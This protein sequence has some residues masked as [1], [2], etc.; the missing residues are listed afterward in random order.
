VYKKN[1]LFNWRGKEKYKRKSEKRKRILKILKS[2]FSIMIALVNIARYVNLLNFDRSLIRRMSRHDDP[3][4][5]FI[6]R[7]YL[8]RAFPAYESHKSCSVPPR[9]ALV[10]AVINRE[11]IC[12]N[13]SC[14]S[15]PR[16]S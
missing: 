2:S 8:R 16:V 5:F 15:V 13:R 9:P 12:P 6:A 4:F 11:A 7:V 3:I 10:A 14:S 1:E